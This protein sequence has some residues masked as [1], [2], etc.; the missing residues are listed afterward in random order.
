MNVKTKLYLSGRT[1][2]SSAT[3]YEIVASQY[4]LPN[5][6][7]IS[8]GEVNIRC[9]DLDLPYYIREFV[10]E[11]Q[12]VIMICNM[13]E[14]EVTGIIFRALDEKAFI[15]YGLGKGTFYGI[16]QLEETFKYGDLIVLVEGAID[17]DSCSIF[18][19]KNCLSVLTSTISKSQLQV[20]KCL[21]NK[22]LL[23][24]DNDEAGM[25]GE[26]LTKKRLLEEGMTCY[27]INK[28]P[29]IK[30]LGDLIDLKKKKDARADFIINNYRAQVQIHGGVLV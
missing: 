26:S 4:K 23:I 5:Y 10:S 1:I 13:I 8:S 3:K 30:D 17:R 2:T 19:T 24:L 7:V 20:L 25:N 21:T 9:K 6:R 12:E 27:T 29:I 15:N 16:G 18:I 22:V 14:S 28:S 11:H